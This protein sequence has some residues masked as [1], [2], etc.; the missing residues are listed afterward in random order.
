MVESAY[1]YANL[2]GKSVK[3]VAEEMY[4]AAANAKNMS[5]DI[6][7][8]FSTMFDKVGNNFTT[9]ITLSKFAEEWYPLSIIHEMYRDFAT[10]RQ[11]MRWTSVED[12]GRFYV[13]GYAKLM[14]GTGSPEYLNTN[15]TEDFYRMFTLPGSPGLNLINIAD[16]MT[17]ADYGQLSQDR[18]D[19]MMYEVDPQTTYMGGLDDNTRECFRKQLDVHD[20]GESFIR[21]S[22]C[23]NSNLKSDD[24][25]YSYCQWHKR[26]TTELTPKQFYTIMKW[27]LP[28]RQ[29]LMSPFTDE[30]IDLAKKLFGEDVL[31]D[32]LMTTQDQMAHSP[33]VIFCNEKKNQGWIGEDIGIGASV[34]SNFYVTPTDVGLCHSKNLALNDVVK[35]ESNAKSKAFVETYDSFAGPPRMADKG[36]YWAEATYILDLNA[37][38]EISTIYPRRNKMVADWPDSIRKVQMQVH[39]AHELAQILWD[40]EQDARSKSLPL[41]AGFEYIVELDPQGQWVTSRFLELSPDQQ[42]CV[43]YDNNNNGKDDPST[44]FLGYTKPNCKYECK[45]AKASRL[46]QCFPWDF[47]H[48]QDE[49]ES[50]N[51]FG[52]CDVFGR[53]CFLNAI[54]NMTHNDHDDCSETCKEACVFLDFYKRIAETKPLVRKTDFYSSSDWFTNFANKCHGDPGLCAYLNNENTTFDDVATTNLIMDY[55]GWSTAE[56]ADS[57]LESIVVVHV[58]YLSPKFEL[59]MLD[60]RLT[61]YDKMASLGGM[62][63][64]LTQLTGFSM[65]NMIHLV[66]LI[67]KALYALCSPEFKT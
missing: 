40:P 30:E 54:A 25:C 57:R 8:Y 1:G 23:Q 61:Y 6:S 4:D 18:L 42:G 7:A 36:T 44:I 20:S 55:T 14:S 66:V 26:L 35:V 58:R 59:T 43:F 47:L 21:L 52:E 60:A 15:V 65:L 22:P 12:L 27:A 51:N 45:V 34:C 38:P 11:A 50:T 63:G 32:D 17:I 49:R 3:Q 10:T 46:C 53:T 19:F 41:K 2:T 13:L 39:S 37:A 33:L 56:I 16:L 5:Q 67:V 28:Q 29:V 9:N 31:R 48:L 64:I 62:F 24:I